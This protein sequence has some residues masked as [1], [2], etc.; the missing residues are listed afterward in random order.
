M[1]KNYEIIDHTADL[2]ITVYGSDLNALFVNAGNAM[3]EIM[4]D[5]S[6]VNDAILKEITVTGVDLEQLMINWLHEMLFYYEVDS[7]LFNKV[8]DLRII[9][10]AQNDEGDEYTLTAK[11]RGETFDIDRHAVLTE[12]K[13]V[14][15]HQIEVKESAGNWQARIIFDL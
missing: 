2:G 4:A 6:N 1:Q 3:A 15:H 14:T 13:A 5:I 10:G 7:I 8:E 11:C 12:I 9:D